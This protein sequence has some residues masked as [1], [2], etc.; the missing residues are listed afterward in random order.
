MQFF[1]ICQGYCPIITDNRRA[2]CNKTKKVKKMKVIVVGKANR[3]GV[4]KKSGNPYDFNI[5]LVTHAQNG[6]EGLNATGIN[7]DPKT[8]PLA[9][10]QVGKVYNVDYD[11]RGYV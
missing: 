7:L 1:G 10:I 4:S 6:I 9:G 2:A 5:A 8:Y 3:S 11:N